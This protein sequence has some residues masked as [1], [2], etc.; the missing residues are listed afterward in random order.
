MKK[1]KLDEQVKKNC[2]EATKG[3]L[4]A[5]NKAQQNVDRVKSQELTRTKDE[6]KTA[7]NAVREVDKKIVE[8][9]K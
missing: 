4:E 5:F 2:S 3:K 1:S 8:A 6:L 7:Q 9:K